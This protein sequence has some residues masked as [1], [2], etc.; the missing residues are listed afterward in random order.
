M[1]HMNDFSAEPEELKKAQR[2]AFESVMNSGYY[3]LGPQVKNFEDNWA[4]TLEARYCVGVANGLDAIEIG[5]RVS[6]IGSGD[7]VITTPMTAFAT[8]LAIVRAGATPVLADIDAST[9]LMD[10]D[11]A[12]RCISKRTRAILLVHLY[13]QI[14]AMET[15]Q[16]LCRDHDILLLEDCAQSHLSRWHGQSAGTF[17]AWGAYSF[18]P[19]KNLGALG[20]AGAFITKD[21]A[22]DK[23]AR[24]LRNYGQSERYHHPTLGMNSRLDEL[25]AAIL[26]AR[27]RFLES[28]TQT[29]REIANI[30]YDGISNPL[31]EVLKRPDAPENHCH[32]LFVVKTNRRSELMEHLKSHQIESLIHY[33]VPIHKQKSLQQVQHDPQGLTQ[34]EKYAETCLS[35]PCHPHM[36][37]ATATHVVEVI[38][39]FV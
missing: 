24:Q 20:D 33:P 34:V 17:G 3:I 37:R 16:N 14:K 2:E 31:V 8:V 4:K 11:S 22:L 25:Q 9:G 38:N 18:Y 23:K 28:F 32:H 5:L 36:T 1:I 29:R 12:K 30:Y 10:P 39:R 27:L 15:W 35:I 7:E 21:E 6:G 13:G 26:S 19:T